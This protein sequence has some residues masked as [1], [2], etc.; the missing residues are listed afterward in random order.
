MVR[1][2]AQDSLVDTN[3]GTSPAPAIRSR[4]VLFSLI[5]S[6]VFSILGASA[7]LLPL[8]GRK[9]L[10]HWDE[11]VYA[12]ISR[13]M[14]SHSWLIPTSNYH[15]WLE[16][17]PL[18]LWISAVFFKYFQVN[19][20]WARV[21]SALSGIA[22]VGVSHWWL[23]KRRGMRAAWLSS[24]I[25]LSTLGFIR[26]C[27]VGETDVLLSLCCFL[28]IWSLTTVGC[29]KPH[30]WY[31]FW[32]GFGLAAMTKGAASVVILLTLAVVAVWGRW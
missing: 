15:V 14:L 3:Q 24:I 28:S 6:T 27:R 25:L 5:R 13:E 7:I 21:G 26:A 19:E 1:H 8:L 17:P 22:L 20:L 29:G 31:L 32:T 30:A 4:A 23:V 11:G 10:A 2:I 9:H 12:E 16:K 18:M